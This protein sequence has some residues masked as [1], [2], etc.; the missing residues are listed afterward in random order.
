LLLRIIH[1]SRSSSAL[2]DREELLL[3]SPAIERKCRS[4]PKKI[5]QVGGRRKTERAKEIPA[6]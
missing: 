2:V 1:R 6:S 5:Q 4:K 3:V